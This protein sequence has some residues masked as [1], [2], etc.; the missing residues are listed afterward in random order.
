MCATLRLLALSMLIVFGCGGLFVESAQADLIADWTFET[1]QPIT[2]GPF[3][4]ELGAGSASG[5]H[6][7]ATSYS[8]PLGNGS[9]HSFSSTHWAIG[10]YYEFDFSTTGRTNLMLT[11]DQT[12]SATGPRDFKLQTSLNGSIWTD[13]TTYTVPNVTWNST[14]RMSASSFGS[15]SLPDGIV[16]VRLVDTSTTSTGGGTVGSTG[17]DRVDNV[18]ISGTSAAT[19]T[20]EPSS[21]ALLS[22]GIAGLVGATWRRRKVVA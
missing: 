8:N 6:T 7:G 17:T 22:L 18:S 1:S 11:F 16:G 20:P 5:F 15:F 10:D 4:P 14:T 2:A 9:A 3:T 21:L 13:L 19:S 12:S